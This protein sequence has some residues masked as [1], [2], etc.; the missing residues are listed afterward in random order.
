MRKGQPQ[1]RPLGW[2]QN[3]REIF[4]NLKASLQTQTKQTGQSPNTGQTHNGD[5]LSQN[6][7]VLSKPSSG[8]QVRRENYTQ[9]ALDEIRKTLHPFKTGDVANTSMESQDSF[10]DV[11]KTFL[12]QLESLGYEEDKAVQALKMTGNKSVEQALE[13]LS[14]MKMLE[15][16]NGIN[17]GLWNKGGRKQSIGTASPGSDSGSVR[18]ESPIVNPLQ[19]LNRPNP[20]GEIP[21]PLSSHSSLSSSYQNSLLQENGH[22][23]PPPVPPRLPLSQTQTM[24]SE[25]SSYVTSPNQISLAHFTPTS[26]STPTNINSNITHMIPAGAS[27]LSP[28]VRDTTPRSYP[29]SKIVHTSSPQTQQVSSG[30]VSQ[31]RGVSPV[32]LGRHN[33]TVDNSGTLPASQQI[34]NSNGR[35]GGIVN[36][37]VNTRPPP[38]PYP[39]GSGQQRTGQP[40]VIIEEKN[41]GSHIIPDLQKPSTYEISLG[42]TANRPESIQINVSKQQAGHAGQAVPVPAW[43]AK[44]DKILINQVQSHP[45]PKPVLRTAT[46]PLS[47]LTT[48]QGQNYRSSVETHVNGPSPQA[49]LPKGNVQIKFTSQ[50]AGRSHA[51]NGRL[52]PDQF[53]QRQRQ[54]TIN[55]RIE[56]PSG[57]PNFQ[58]PQVQYGQSYQMLPQNLERYCSTSD[59]PM[60]TPR[61]GSPMSGSRLTNQSPLSIS[62]NPSTSSDIP[63]RPPPP[64]PGKPLTINAQ[65][66][67]VQVV[68]PIPQMPHGHMIPQIVHSHPAAIRTGQAIPLEPS[69]QPTQPPLPPRVPITQPQGK[70]PPPPPPESESQPPIPPKTYQSNSE[71]TNYN[72]GDTDTETM[73]TTSDMS[74]TQDKHRCTSPIPER[75]PE[76]EEKDRLR[77]D[78]LVRNYS[79]QAYKFFME[80]HVENLMKS[81]QQRITRRQQLEQEMTKI[82]LSDE[83]QLQMRRML[84][85]KESNYIRMKRS[86]MNKDMF[87]KIKKLGVGA[88]GEV[89]LVR[90][91]DVR[92]LYAMKM[93]RKS[94]VLKRNQ[95]AHVKA[96]RDI[97]AE[98]DNEWVVKLYYSFQSRDN[99]YFIMDY[100]PGG[101]LMGLLIKLEIFEEPLACF[102]I[103]ELVLAIESVHK[104]GFIHRDIKPDNILIDRHGHIKLTDFGLCTGFR[105]THNSKYYQPPDGLHRPQDSM[106]MSGCMESPASEECRC[107][108]IKTL[109]RRRKRDQQRC[110]AHSLVGTPNYIAPEVLLRQGYTACCDWWSVGVILYEMLVGHPPFYAQTPQE[111]Q[112]KVIHWDKTLSIPPEPRLSEAAVDLIIRLCCDADNRLGR[113]GATEIKS[114]SFFSSIQFEGLRK[115]KAPYVPKISHATDTSN[116]DPVDEHDSDT[117]SDCEIKKL[118]HPVNGRHPEHAFFEFTFRRFFDDGG[119]PY[120]TVKHAKDCNSDETDSNTSE[121]NSPVYV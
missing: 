118:D 84:Q 85:Q 7:L 11:N 29:S 96:E 53:A 63:D 98:A 1:R 115:Q 72:E 61:S 17:K 26:Q 117:G 14:N 77:R 62:S 31:H 13:F 50:G 100:V 58:T 46:A 109:E 30:P 15:G 59:T 27:P 40:T 87:Q 101:D 19:G 95:V 2:N 74:S 91:K 107:S 78:T 43:N 56:N 66:P 82:N 81:H 104:M 49:D 89:T 120:P 25:N 33:V 119:H 3:N 80:Q 69:N 51:N 60:S 67:Q 121:T 75:K 48:P 4:E 114:H 102:Y 110:L 39:T 103:A 83:A 37:R 9:N 34:M 76:S 111:T 54:Q 8:P 90:K 99:L 71:Q 55:I 79:P 32:S 5:G 112:Y 57:Q 65:L 6:T 86:K 52:T 20:H 36:I 44:Q 10:T 23:T 105:W 94:E 88:F 24:S 47:P 45:V 38:P 21:K 18:S 42:H 22:Q 92:Q 97:L 106:D 70:P 28:F 41:N 73:S 12:H 116:F 64:Y 68:Q 93:L 113:N 35:P 108:K 16:K